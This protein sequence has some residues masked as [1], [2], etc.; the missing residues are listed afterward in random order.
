MKGS[1]TFSGSTRPPIYYLLHIVARC[2]KEICA[3]SRRP[4][5]RKCRKG[6]PVVNSGLPDRI[7]HRLKVDVLFRKNRPVEDGA[8]NGA[9]CRL[10]ADRMM[11][12]RRI[13]SSRA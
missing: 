10:A 9:A 11:D 13:Q 6:D 2:V 12:R 3:N 5:K 8:S 4:I 1:R 7:I